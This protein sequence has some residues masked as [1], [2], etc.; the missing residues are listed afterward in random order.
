MHPRTL[1]WLW[2]IRE[3]AQLILV[4]T[5]RET[6]DT[7]LDNQLL[8]YA[9]ERNFE[10]IGEAIRRIRDLDPESAQRIKAAK[11]FIAFRNVLIHVYDDIDHARVWQ[12]IQESLPRLK[13]E[14]DELLREAD[15][16][17]PQ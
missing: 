16:P 11:E 14:A 5:A 15:A 12:V 13:A 1:A 4:E 2:H 7:Y 10:I 8:R 6:F 3:A 9:V 17:E